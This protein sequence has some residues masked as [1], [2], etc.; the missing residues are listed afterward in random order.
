MVGI[1]AGISLL[2]IHLGKLELSLCHFLLFC[3]GLFT[4][5]NRKL[6]RLPLTIFNNGLQPRILD[7][8]I[9]RSITRTSKI[10]SD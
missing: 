9:K 3:V 6:D 8:K 10:K 5:G 2:N 7:I 1:V 4:F